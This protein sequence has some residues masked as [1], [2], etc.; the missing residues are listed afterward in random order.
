M[1]FDSITEYSKPKKIRPQK[2]HRQKIYFD[3]DVYDY[4]PPKSAGKKKHSRMVEV[5]YDEEELEPYKS[6]LK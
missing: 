3:D 5:E 1:D 6:Y 4:H 2:T